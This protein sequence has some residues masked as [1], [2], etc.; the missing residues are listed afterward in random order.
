MVVTV[1]NFW[2]EHNCSAQRDPK[3][4]WRKVS[5]GIGV[6]VGPHLP[7]G[8]NLGMCP[9]DALLPDHQ[10]RMRPEALMKLQKRTKPL[11]LFAALF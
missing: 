1:K 5:D 10:A 8:F 9:L 6:A 4:Y 3:S 7:S 11:E 2:V